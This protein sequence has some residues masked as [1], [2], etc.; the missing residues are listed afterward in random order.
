M[1][2]LLTPAYWVNVFAF[3]IRIYFYFQNL[4]Q[5]AS[6]NHD[7]V[8][9]STK[10]AAD[11]SKPPVQWHF[12]AV[13]L[14][15]IC[16]STT[17]TKSSF[18]TCWSSFLKILHSSFTWSLSLSILSSEN[19]RKRLSLNRSRV[20]RSSLLEMLHAPLYRYVA[21]KQND[22]S[23]FP[24]LMAYK[25]QHKKVE[26]YCCTKQQVMD[27]FYISTCLLYIHRS[28][29]L[30]NEIIWH[31]FFH[32]LSTILGKLDKEGLRVWSFLRKRNSVDWIAHFSF[33]TR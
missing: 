15:N 17:H 1:S 2:K 8:V 18:A 21:A 16:A 3:W 23:A 10:E 7:L 14:V 11:A 24:Y 12:Y 28:S 19:F 9:K 33:W 26:F 13:V 30:E 27:I 32:K 20:R 4:S 31:I 29:C 22:S 5:L 6:I 25:L